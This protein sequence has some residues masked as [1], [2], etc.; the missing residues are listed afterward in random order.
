[1]A[2][3]CMRAE[4]PSKHHYRVRGQ[5]ARYE[6]GANTSRI[7]NYPRCWWQWVRSEISR[8]RETTPTLMVE[9][10]DY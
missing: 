10:H 8:R 7:G 2:K 1:M 6:Q 5:Q 3:P 9:V 4:T